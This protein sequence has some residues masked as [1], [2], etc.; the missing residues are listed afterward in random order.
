MSQSTKGRKLIGQILKARGIVRE[1]QIQEALAE[2]RKHGGL[3]GQHLVA[4]GHCKATDIAAAL[5]EQ[6]GLAAVDL[7]RVKPSPEALAKVDA[8]T[9]HAYCVLPFELAGGRLKV[10]IADPLNTAV[11]EDLAF[12]TGLVIDGAVADQETLK[13]KVKEFYGEEGSLADAIAAAAAV[14]GSDPEKAAQSAPVVRLLNSILH[15]AIADRASDVH[16]EVFPK[17]LR[18]RYRV[19]GALYEIEA[20]PVHLAA[21]LLARIKVMS[22]LDIA[23]TKMPQDGRIALSIDGRPVDLRVAT[24]PGIGGEGCVLRV[25]DRSAVSLDLVALGL[26]PEDIETLG[27]LTQLPHGIVLVTGPTG[28]GKTTTL[29]AM[30]NLANDAAVKI[31]TVE[32]PV[33]YDIDGIVQVPINEE[34]G[35]TYPKVLRTVLRQ[36]PDKILVGEV[37]DSET[38]LVAVEASLTGHTVFATVHTNDAPSAITRLVDLG[39]EPFLI[40]ATLE[41]IVA[42]RLV[43]RVCRACKTS[44]QADDEV[45]RELGREAAELRGVT[46]YYGKG[47]DECFHTGYRGR[48]AICEIM[49]VD[50]S[51]RRAILE[52]ASTA[53][54]RELARQAGMRT[55]REAGFKAVLEGVTTLEEVRRETMQL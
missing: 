39:L 54:I 25:L 24:L 10:A 22:D 5:A 27:E 9:A 47:C 11:L 3:I 13:S 12:Q 8:S 1:A 37:R 19:D 28:S 31:I 23:E 48:T 2:Q 55:L 35:V 34:I 40:T 26:A 18:V 43:R 20:P 52:R 21:P 38:A 4:L 16:F 30:L 33:E 14:A 41:A 50:A 17:E 49:R 51:L 7:A 46:L 53:T 44:Y 45:L 42:Q 29:Y 15:R 32:D 36:D 6:V